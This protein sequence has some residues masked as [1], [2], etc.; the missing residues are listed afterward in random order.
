MLQAVQFI[1]DVQGGKNRHF[2]I[3]DCERSRRDF[4]HPTVDELGE[5]NNIFGIAVGANVVCLVVN[6][7]PDSW[8]GGGIHNTPPQCYSTIPGGHLLNSSTISGSRAATASSIASTF[9][10][11]MS[12]SASSFSTCA[13]KRSFSFSTLPMSPRLVAFSFCS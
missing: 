5:L 11:I 12:R 2:Q 8:A 6:L 3:I 9:I 7:D 1:R 10:R 4:P 13:S